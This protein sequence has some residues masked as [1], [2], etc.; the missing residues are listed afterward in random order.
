MTKTR[1]TEAQLSKITLNSTIPLKTWECVTKPSEISPSSNSWWL[2]RKDRPNR[3]TNNGD[4][5]G[6]AK[7]YVV[8]HF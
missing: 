3:S 8:S 4:V 5:A 6:T 2:N 1:T 7:S